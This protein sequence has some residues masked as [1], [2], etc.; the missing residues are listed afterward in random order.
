MFWIVALAAVAIAA[1]VIRH[2]MQDHR[3]AEVQRRE[4]L[5]DIDLTARRAATAIAETAG[6]AA[7]PS[8]LE[9]PRPVQRDGQ[10][11]RAAGMTRPVDAH[12]P[13]AAQ[14]NRARTG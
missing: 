6:P 2:A 7:P 1:S 10:R 8:D 11:D 13:N 5:E 14:R 9:L 12:D 4:A 3:D